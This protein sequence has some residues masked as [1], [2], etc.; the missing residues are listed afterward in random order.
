MASND[1]GAGG[2]VPKRVLETGLAVVHEGELVY[3]AAGSE[4]QAEAALDASAQDITVYF[5]VEVEIRSIE[6]DGARMREI[7]EQVLAEMA[8]SLASKR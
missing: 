1:G 6:Y 8:R 2:A 5:P 3:P 7:A 4:A